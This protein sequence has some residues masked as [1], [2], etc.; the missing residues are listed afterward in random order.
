MKTETEYLIKHLKD[1]MITDTDETVQP[2][3]PEPEIQSGP[4]ESKLLKFIEEIKKNPTDYNDKLVLSRIVEI[5]DEDVQNCFDARLEQTAGFYLNMVIL[6][7]Q[8]L[9][10]ILM[11]RHGAV[12]VPQSPIQ[13]PNPNKPLVTL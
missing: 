4:L 2:T 13:T 6:A 5:L 3:T 7:T 12:L 1:N 8:S 9:V 10:K 11:H